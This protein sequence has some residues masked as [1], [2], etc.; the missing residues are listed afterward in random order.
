MGDIFRPGL[1]GLVPTLSHFVD[2]CLKELGA[3][4]LFLLRHSIH[5]TSE[6]FLN[7]SENHTRYQGSI[8]KGISVKKMCFLNCNNYWDAIIIP[9]LDGKY[10]KLYCG[11]L[12]AWYT[13]TSVL[14]KS[15]L[16]YI[17]SS[18]W[19]TECHWMDILL[20]SFPFYFLPF[21]LF[22]FLSLLLL[23]TEFL[24][25]GNDLRQTNQWQDT[26]VRI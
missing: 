26:Y 5:R 2:R 25:P 22:L 6:A 24:C 9:I 23:L 18:S 12:N 10:G 17:A 7:I 11:F 14:R 15:F 16:S 1:S 13:R 20:S 21:F 19:Q 8:T 3:R 4:R